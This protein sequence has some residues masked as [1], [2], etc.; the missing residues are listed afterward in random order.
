ME[1]KIKFDKAIVMTTLEPQL[2]DEKVIKKELRIY[3][4]LILNKS[5]VEIYLNNKDRLEGY[6]VDFNIDNKE[7]QTII[8][9]EE[10]YNLI[11]DCKNIYDI[12]MLE[13][14]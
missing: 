11:I 14:D 3:D 12:N 2:T 1:R 8:L 10:M 13:E 7:N 9:K 4:K 5:Y 6:I